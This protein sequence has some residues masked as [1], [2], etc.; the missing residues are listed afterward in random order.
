MSVKERIKKEALRIAYGDRIG[1]VQDVSAHV[2]S[3]T[4][5]ARFGFELAVSLL[6]ESYPKDSDGPYRCGE[7]FADWLERKLGEE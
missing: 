3:F 5:G 2:Q 4:S 1:K 6:R 7:W